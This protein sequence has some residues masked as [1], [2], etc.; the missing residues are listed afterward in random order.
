MKVIL[1]EDI[2]GVGRK[3]DV[4][5]LSDGYVRNYLLLRKL[6]KLADEKSVA[7]LLKEKE[8]K[9][10]REEEIKTALKKIAK[11]L[12]EIILDFQVKTGEKDQIFGSI[13]NEEIKK[14][15]EELEP[16][17]K[18]Y[19]PDFSVLIDKPL[20]KLGDHEVPLNLGLGIKSEA[21]VRLLSE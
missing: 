10:K 17:I 21:K 18:K 11:R 15:I 12:P 6:V 7:A 9:L 8:E 3:S 19:N 16:E 4:K 1:L 5:N 13:T 14:K 20:K 2:K